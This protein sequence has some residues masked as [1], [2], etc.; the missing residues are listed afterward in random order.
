MN[1]KLTTDLLGRK[2]NSASFFSCA[3]VRENATCGAHAWCT[4]AKK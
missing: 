4:S 2:K 3:Q 1:C